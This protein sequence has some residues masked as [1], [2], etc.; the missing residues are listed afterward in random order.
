M[1]DEPE[2]ELQEMLER[3]NKLSL[4]CDTK[5][6]DYKMGVSL[7]TNTVLVSLPVHGSPPRA[8]TQ[9]ITNA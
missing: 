2:N 5:L 4:F 1:Y 9:W 8:L 6:F 7:N 3:K